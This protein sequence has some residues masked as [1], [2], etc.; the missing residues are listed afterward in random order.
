M[1]SWRGVELTSPWL[2]ASSNSTCEQN[3][4]CSTALPCILETVTFSM[5]QCGLG[6][7]SDDAAFAN[8]FFPSGI[9]HALL[10]LLPFPSDP[11]PFVEFL[12]MLS[13]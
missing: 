6:F 8:R 9:W 12:Q 4:L 3:S 13:V 5:P 2:C 11:L 10:H 1:E 7:R